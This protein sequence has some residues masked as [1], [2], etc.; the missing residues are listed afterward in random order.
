[1]ERSPAQQPVACAFEEPEHPLG[2]AHRFRQ[3]IVEEVLT[4]AQ[5]ESGRRRSRGSP[6]W[7]VRATGM[8]SARPVVFTTIRSLGSGH[9]S[10]LCTAP[11][12]SPLI[13]QQRQPLFQLHHGVAGGEHGDGHGVQ[14]AS[15]RTIPVLPDRGSLMPA[16][17]ARHAVLSH[18]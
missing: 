18:T 5:I 7:M 8:G 4:E 17:A 12:S 10:T 9:F 3:L 6:A 13:E 2:A 15:L 16:P 14:A 1:M 11:C